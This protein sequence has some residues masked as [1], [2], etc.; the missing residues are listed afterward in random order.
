MSYNE[1]LEHRRELLE[2]RRFALHRMMEAQDEYERAFW[3]VVYRWACDEI[4]RHSTK[5][6]A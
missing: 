6:S 3:R 4:K 5:W 1:L 2:H